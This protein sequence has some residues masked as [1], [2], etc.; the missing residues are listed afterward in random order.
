MVYSPLMAPRDTSFGIGSTDS[1]SSD[2]CEVVRKLRPPPSLE[3][4]RVIEQVV[5]RVVAS[6]AKEVL[7][8]FTEHFTKDMRW[9]NNKKCYDAIL[10]LADAFSVAAPEEA[11]ALT[12]AAT[13]PETARSPHYTVRAVTR[14]ASMLSL[15]QG[16]G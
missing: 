16:R 9:R 3:T 4:D 14:E 15:S 5:A 12:A 10:A 13:G 11:A 8:V 1:S 6:G 2:L 7:P